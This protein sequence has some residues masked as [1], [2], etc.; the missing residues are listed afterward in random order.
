MSYSSKGSKNYVELTD[1]EQEQKIIRVNRLVIIMFGSET[2]G[3]CRH[4]TPIYNSL[5]QK[6]PNIAFAHVECSGKIEVDNP[7]GGVPI[8]AF[9][10]DGEPVDKLIGADERKLVEKINNLNI[11]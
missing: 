6:Y 8:F 1:S 10:K 5:R 11:Q 7:D 3:H 9:Y 2:C 4:I